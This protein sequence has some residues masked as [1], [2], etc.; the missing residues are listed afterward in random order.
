MERK[1]P[2]AKQLEAMADDHGLYERKRAI[3]RDRLGLSPSNH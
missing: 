2:S 3:V 1:E